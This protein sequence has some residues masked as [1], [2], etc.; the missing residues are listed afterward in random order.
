MRDLHSKTTCWNPVFGNYII[1]VKGI[2]FTV[3]L[4]IIILLFIKLHTAI[5][6][7]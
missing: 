7:L 4:D 2:N 6:K 3:L 1:S 5:L